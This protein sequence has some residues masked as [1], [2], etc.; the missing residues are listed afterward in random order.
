M[1]AEIVNRFPNFIRC[2]TVYL[3][4]NKVLKKYTKKELFECTQLA[5]HYSFIFS[6]LCNLIG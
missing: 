6:T 2:L 5:A 4:Y 1:C 3:K